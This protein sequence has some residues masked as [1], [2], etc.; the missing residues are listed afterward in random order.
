MVVKKSSRREF[1]RKAAYA[2]PVLL[3]LPATPSFAQ[4]GSGGT[5]GTGGTG[6]DPEGDGDPCLAGTPA[7]G[8]DEV[9]ICHLAPD[10]QTGAN[11]GVTEAELPA[12]ID[13]GDV[14]GSCEEF[15]CGRS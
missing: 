6:G 12:H 10:A 5:G 15:F 4:R 2:S 1:I 8:Q 14:F 3:T 7:V 9:L 13:H 11:L